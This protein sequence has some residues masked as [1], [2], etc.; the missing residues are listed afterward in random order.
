MRLLCRLRVDEIHHGLRLDEIQLPVEERPLR[1]LPAGGLAAPGGEQRPQ[2]RVQHDGAAVAVQLGAVLACIA[3]GRGK[4]HAQHVVDDLPRL[5]QQLA[6]HHGTAPLRPGLFPV[7]GAEHRVQRGAGA[8]AGQPQYA[9]G[10]RL[11][12]RCDGGDGIRHGEPSL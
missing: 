7:F 10:T 3:V 8:C 2:P 4:H 1:E 5:V 11:H 9:D 12:G 6:Q